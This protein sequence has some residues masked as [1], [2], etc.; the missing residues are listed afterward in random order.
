MRTRTGVL[1]GLA[2]PIVVLTSQLHGQSIEWIEVPLADNTYTE[3]GKAMRSDTIEI[4]MP[5]FG[6]LEYKLGMQ[7]GDT[8]VY[9]WTADLDNPD[10]LYAEFHGHTEAEPGGEGTVMFYRKAEGGAERGALSAPFSGIHGWYLEN[11]SS[12]AV[13]VRLEVS[14]FYELLEQ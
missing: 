14:G 11:R 4:P 7:E 13:V 6:R 5:A 2:L 10:M 3:Q 12:A 1:L 8:I 9:S